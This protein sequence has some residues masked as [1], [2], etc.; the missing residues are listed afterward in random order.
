MAFKYFTIHKGRNGRNE[1]RTILQLG[2]KNKSENPLKYADSSESEPIK[3]L[4]NIKY[5]QADGGKSVS[6]GDFNEDGFVYL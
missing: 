1:K 4:S 3:K 2:K 5:S 6:L